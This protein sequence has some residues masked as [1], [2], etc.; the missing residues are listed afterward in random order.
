MVFSFFSMLDSENTTGSLFLKQILKIFD[1]SVKENE[2]TELCKS[3]R[4]SFYMNPNFPAFKFAETMTLLFLASISLWCFS[5]VYRCH[6]YFN[7][8][9]EFQEDDVDTKYSVSLD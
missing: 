7:E 1:F 8:V 6:K 5:V 2:I 4:K 3:L 9:V